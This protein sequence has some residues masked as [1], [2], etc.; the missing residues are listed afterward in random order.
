MSGGSL[1]LTEGKRH[2]LASAP[3]SMAGGGTALGPSG[4]VAL[5]PPG[6]GWALL[7]DPSGLTCTSHGHVET[8]GSD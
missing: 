2:S 6:L 4:A 8:V 3:V 1:A 5:V 7:G